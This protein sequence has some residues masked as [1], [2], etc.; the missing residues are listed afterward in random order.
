M[1]ICHVRRRARIIGTGAALLVLLSASGCVSSGAASR[2]A[3]EPVEGPSPALTAFV[4]PP[5]SAAPSTFWYWVS[6]DITKEGLTKDLEVMRKIGIA[7]AYI[8]NVDTN[9]EHRGATPSLSPEWWEALRHAMEEGARLGV[10]I[11]MF[12][13]PGWSQSGGPWVKPE[14]SMRYL[15]VQEYTVSGQ[16]DLPNRL[17]AAN[18]DWQSVRL[19]AYPEKPGGDNLARGAQ[20][21]QAGRALPGLGDGDFSTIETVGILAGREDASTPIEIMLGG[22]K[23]VRTLQIYP[24]P[25]AFYM[26]MDLQVPDGAGGW[27]SVERFPV[28]RRVTRV[29]L[30]AMN[31]G[32]IA[33]RI[34]AT[35]SDRFRLVV[36][37]GP[38]GNPVRLAEIALREA[39][40][41]ERYV[42]KQLGKMW[43]TPEPDYDAYLW[44]AENAED[45]P[46]FAVPVGLVVDLTDKL[47]ADGTLAWN[48][49][50][51]NW[52]LAW[53]G[54]IP[55]GAE[56]GPSTPAATG[57]E[58]DKMN[59][60]HLKSH[61]NA[62]VGRARAALSSAARDNFKLVIADSYEQGAQNWT[63]DMAERF[64]A[65]YGYDPVPFLP[66]L[67]GAIVDSTDASDRFLWDLRRLV[68]DLIST[69]YVGGMRKLSHEAGMQLWLENYGHWGFP[70]E[71]LQYGGQSDQVGAEF[72]VNPESRGDIEIPAAVSA[73][74]VYAQPRASA[75]AYT[76]EAGAGHW[77]LAPWSLKRLG[78]KATSLGINHFVLH[79]NMHQPRD[80]LPGVNSWFGSEF[81][82]NNTWYLE[83]KPW[84]DY[85]RRI[86][87]VLQSGVPQAEVLYFIGEDT[88]KMAGLARP[89]PP[90]GVAF[91]YVNA[92]A[93]AESVK[94]IDGR[95]VLR[96]GGTYAILAMP[97]IEA[98]TPQML[99]VLAGHVAAGGQ[100]YASPPQRSPSLA[101]GP[102]ADTEVRELA[103]QMWGTCGQ[104]GL[105]SVAYGKGRVYC[106]G[107]LAEVL[108]EQGV[109]L[110]VA[111]I[112]YTK[113]RWT[114]VSTK[115]EDIFFLANQ[116]DESVTIAP[117]LATDHSLLQLWDPVS[118]ERLS[119]KAERRP[120][121]LQSG[122]VVL[123]PF[124]SV[125]LV[126][127]NTE[128]AQLRAYDP[129]REP[130]SLADL[131]RD[132]EV[133]FDPKW[134]GPESVRFAELRDWTLNEEPGIRYYSGRASY[135][136]TY[137]LDRVPAGGKVWLD[138]GEVRDMAIV[139][140][141]GQRIGTVW[142]APWR[143]D[144][145]SV[146]RTGANDIEIEVINTWANRIIGDLQAPEGQ[147]R[148][149]TAVIDHVSADSPL[150]PA[151][152]LGPVRLLGE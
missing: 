50:A 40:L 11:G 150:N 104:Q 61:F 87:G 134:G 23:T 66:T 60:T 97:P 115:Q 117:L 138:L 143:I 129:D 81:N 36:S 54:L 13:S 121:G 96:N 17:A 31:Q 84:I 85:L 90:A 114:Q 4:S 15:S 112:D 93:L 152:L 119:V 5:Q 63:D 120:G 98:M 59:A 92:E 16:D 25:D 125:F 33:I 99:R 106:S 131:S 64:V 43:Q 73:S 68:A 139:T 124:Q 14:Q 118:E 79:V 91:D 56:N 132:W 35:T 41:I 1:N 130:R 8:G 110:Q 6:D 77:T 51:G 116:T 105:S 80:D 141:N 82:R 70:G 135:R 94:V 146:L 65:R 10:N 48:V 100:M 103:A 37:R 123:A 27:R 75:E 24:G 127:A 147:P 102:E 22:A 128:P 28:D 89:E 72:W 107:A 21:S 95:W 145:S 38:N 46:E 86:H 52:R 149:T 122:A 18:P 57:L 137:T 142:T 30:G 74:R 111:G 148:Y 133:A 26:E 45:D 9:P 88:P 20:F 140:V 69:E 136:K 58:I 2:A 144:V 12:N 71:F 67:T 7:E 49:P 76:N 78:D 42:E 29:Q 62:Y 108:S 113:V 3:T 83:A 47:S 32:P 44:P 109:T 126:A 55:T 34:P 101:G 53:F 151:G 19:L 39:P